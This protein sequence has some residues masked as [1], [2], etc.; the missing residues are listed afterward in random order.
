MSGFMP[1]SITFMNSETG[2]LT[3]TMQRGKANVGCVLRTT[4]GGHKWQEIL[5]NGT[6]VS[7][8]YAL[9]HEVWVDVENGQHGELYFSSNEGRV[10]K[11]IDRLPLQGLDFTSV[12]DGWAITGNY[13]NTY[14]V[15]TTD[16]G[17]TWTNVKST[18]VYTKRL[19]ANGNPTWI[20]FSGAKSGLLLDTSESASGAQGKALL[21]TRNRGKSWSII[22]NIFIDGK[23]R[24]NQLGPGGYADGIDVIPGHPNDAY[25]WESRGSLLYTSDG[26]KRWGIS[27]LVKPSEIEARGVSML[28]PQNGFVLLQG[29]LHRDFILE[30]TKDGGRIWNIIYSWK[31]S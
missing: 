16:G 27:R 14:V 30:D 2:Y 21:R 4:D 5:H 25:L 1:Q 26:G 18:Q 12:N 22:S 28:T 8:V 17:R 9:D 6:D 24:G 13:V 19:S 23:N 31:L 7:N 29:M 11:P 3:G 10:F 20:S 15:T